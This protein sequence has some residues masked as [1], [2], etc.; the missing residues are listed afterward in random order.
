MFDALICCTLILL[1]IDFEPVLL[2]L[3]ALYSILFY[4]DAAYFTDDVCL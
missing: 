1:L 3:T 2:H 4:S